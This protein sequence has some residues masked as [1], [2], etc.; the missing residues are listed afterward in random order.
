MSVDKILVVMLHLSSVHRYIIFGITFNLALRML[1]VLPKAPP[2]EPRKLTDRERQLLHEREENT[3]RELRLFLRDVINKL[4][5]DRKFLIFARPV[6]ID[7][8]R[9]YVLYSWID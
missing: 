4:V 7:D 8:V 6:D 9:I 1:E 5:K 3:L 2:P